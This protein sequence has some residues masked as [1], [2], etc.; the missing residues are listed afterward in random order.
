MMLALKRIELG[1]QIQGY[2]KNE[3]ERTIGDL[4]NSKVSVTDRNQ[5]G[6]KFLQQLQQAGKESFGKNLYQSEIF[7]PEKWRTNAE[8]V[9]NSIQN[10]LTQ[11]QKYHN[12]K[13]YMGSCIESLYCI[14][15]LFYKNN[16]DHAI[17]E[18]L[19]NALTNASEK[20]WEESSGILLAGLQAVSN[21]SFNL[22]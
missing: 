22:N 7:I 1:I 3:V 19:F 6:R 5:I 11:T 21:S 15:D 8:Q 16:M 4:G 13:N 2:L 20:T 9:K 17:N 14:Y 18:I 12:E 10:A